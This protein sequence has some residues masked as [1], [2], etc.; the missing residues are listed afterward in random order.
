MSIREACGLSCDHDDG[1]AAALS[2]EDAID[3]TALSTDAVRTAPKST[4]K[5]PPASSDGDDS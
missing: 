5:T 2:R 1:V 4:K 3:A